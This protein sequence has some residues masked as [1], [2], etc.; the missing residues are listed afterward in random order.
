MRFKIRSLRNF[1]LSEAYTFIWPHPLTS[2]RH[3][4]DETALRL[5]QNHKICPGQ[6]RPGMS[7]AGIFQCWWRCCGM[8]LWYGYSAVVWWTSCGMVDTLWYGFVVWKTRCGSVVWWTLTSC[9]TVGAPIRMHTISLTVHLSICFLSP[10]MHP[11][12]IYFLPHACFDTECDKYIWIFE[13]IGH[14]Y[15]FGHSFVSIFLFDF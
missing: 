10:V 7:A 5:P 11:Y 13:Y 2:K 12:L 6:H 9:G 15:I 4:R 8:V 14:K 3:H 1:H